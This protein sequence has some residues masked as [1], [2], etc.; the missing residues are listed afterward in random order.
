MF[1]PAQGANRCVPWCSCESAPRGS[2]LPSSPGRSPSEAPRDAGFRTA[3]SP[4]P[5]HPGYQTHQGPHWIQDPSPALL[6]AGPHALT[7][8]P[9]LPA[10]DATGHNCPPPRGPSLSLPPT[11]PPVL[12]ICPCSPHPPPSLPSSLN[13]ISAPQTVWPSQLK[14]LKALSTSTE[15]GQRGA[16]VMA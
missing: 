4:Y 3:S 6:P 13:Q 11:R 5:G 10:C 2:I 16:G 1:T 12:C 15:G 8:L 7:A 14:T 9:P